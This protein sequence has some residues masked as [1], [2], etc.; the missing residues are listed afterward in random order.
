MGVGSE[1]LVGAGVGVLVAVGVG[2]L[3]GAGV[4]VLVGAGVGVLVGAGTGVL[5]AVGVGVLVGAGVGVLVGAGVL[6]AVGAGVLVG[7]SMLV[8][9]GAGVLGRLENR[10]MPL[11]SGGEDDTSA[12]EVTASEA[13]GP[14]PAVT[15]SSESPHPAPSN[16]ARPTTTVKPAET[17]T[18]VMPFMPQMPVLLFLTCIRHA[19][20]TGCGSGTAVLML[21]PPRASGN[22]A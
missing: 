17:Q 15:S 6:V 5:V 11:A 12:G 3:V 21:L 16:S 2:V 14:E 8:T 1:V 19:V 10:S 20:R 4:G 13:A 9:V 22:T 18:L 7:V